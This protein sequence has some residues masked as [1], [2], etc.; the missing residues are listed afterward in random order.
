MEG[1]AQFSQI[2]LLNQDVM[3]NCTEVL[4]SAHIMKLHSEFSLQMD[5]TSRGGDALVLL[6]IRW[7]S[8][9]DRGFY[10]V[11]TLAH[12]KESIRLNS[13]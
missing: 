11:C 4:S 10:N 8:F 5:R 12:T 6:C 7:H 3:C 13:L 2:R 9:C 1:N